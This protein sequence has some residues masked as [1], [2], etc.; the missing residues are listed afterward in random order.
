VFLRAWAFLLGKTVNFHEKYLSFIRRFPAFFSFVQL[1]HENMLK[2]K[3]IL[4]ILVWMTFL[5][6]TVFA[7]TLPDRGGRE[8]SQT[9]P[10]P[11]AQRGEQS[12]AKQIEPLIKLWQLKGYG[13]FQDSARM[14]TLQDYYHLYHPVFK[15][16]LTAS[17]VG[18]YATPY[19]DNNFF[20]RQSNLDFL[21]LET[22]EAYLLT[23]QTVKY[24]NTRTPYT[25]LD[26]TQSEHRTRKNETRF[27][28]LHSQN[29]NPY[30]NFTFRYD[31]ARSAGQYKSQETKNNFVTLYSSYNKD[32]LS[33][34]GGF[35]SNSILNNENGGLKPNADLLGEPDTEFLDVNLTSVHSDFANT[36]VFATGEYRFGRFVEV[37]LTDTI[38][39]YD[40]SEEEERPISMVFKP[41]AGIL[42]SFE[43]QTNRKEY[44]D[45]EDNS[46]S[47]FQ[48][49]YYG[50]AYTKDSIRFGKVSN[51]IQ[52]K[53]YENPE[54]KTSFGKRAFIGQEFI[55]TT[56]PGPATDVFRPAV[57]KYSNV[58]TG[59]GI[60]RKTGSFWRWNFDGRIFFL[61][62]N[63][64]QTELSGVVTKPLAFLGDSLATLNLN[65]RIENKMPHYFQEEFYSKRIRWKEDLKMEQ[66]MTVQG[67][68]KF[69]SRKLELTGNYAI[70]NNFIYNDTLGIP[71]QYGGQLLVLSAYADKDF[72]FR[73]FHFRTRL[74]W[75]KASN[76]SVLHLPDFSAFVSGYYKFVISK[77]MFTQLGFDVRYN[78]RYYADAYHP[79]TGFFY[80][81][82]E[83]KYGNF[84]YIDAY[85][86]L[87]LKRTRVFFKMMNL[88][89]EF[90]QQEYMTIPGYPM[91][92]MTFRMGVAWAFY[93]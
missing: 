10:N 81:Q 79:A 9:L 17:Y 69:P 26:F 33:I 44:N 28:V 90:I 12:T 66:R 89:S 45:D 41:F 13:A 74:L 31:Q 42:Y 76:E 72:N 49:D 60:F 71:S 80:L 22:R 27:N 51:I 40:E 55:K 87:R 77:V 59:G 67:S 5:H 23:P 47:F 85:A 7:Q 43:Y 21:F 19:L 18:N 91:N 86:S 48:H 84:P 4:F 63:A 25:L 35:I 65:G 2:Q 73:N 14:D 29:V 34:H 37:E 57:K 75:Q 32:N 68:L 16:T 24:F 62:R 38:P 64:G 82:N 92:R 78:T 93:D 3:L 1:L 39:G 53:H 88:G 83:E 8:G 58:Y 15:N 46:N 36:F 30:L 11:Q 50:D 70:I 54:R 61:G 56:M 6:G 52:L 20:N